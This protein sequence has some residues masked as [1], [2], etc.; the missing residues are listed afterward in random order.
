[1]SDEMPAPVAGFF[2]RI[3]RAV[4]SF[5]SERHED[6]EA[7]EYTASWSFTVRTTPDETD[8]GYV[9]SID[10]LPGCIS[11]GATEEEALEGLAE[12]MRGIVAVR[13]I[14]APVDDGP[15][16]ADDGGTRTRLVAL[17]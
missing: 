8:G 14:D 9:A 10:G 1:M 17:G 13:L 16:R 4:R 5:E 7:A 3:R 6:H 12:A 11:D 15:D 2:R